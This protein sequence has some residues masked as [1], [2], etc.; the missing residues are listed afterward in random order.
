[1]QTVQTVRQPLGQN[2]QLL[3][4]DEMFISTTLGY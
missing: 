3:Q 2:F 4:T 1:M